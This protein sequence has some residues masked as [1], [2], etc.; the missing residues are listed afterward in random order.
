MITTAAVITIAA[1]SLGVGFVIGFWVR[2]GA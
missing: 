2:G 1:I